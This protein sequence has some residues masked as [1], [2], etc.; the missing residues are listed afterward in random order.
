MSNIGKMRIKGKAKKGK[1]T[2]KA[3]IKHPQLSFQE[4]Q[5]AKKDATFITH[6]V[7][8]VNGE[9]VFE[10]SGSQFLS[11]NPYLKFSFNGGAKGDKIE[12]AV[13][14][15]VLAN[16]TALKDVASSG[17]KNKKTGKGKIK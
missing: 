17:K 8:T 1:T 16:N 2:V 5:R 7:G 6:V 13:E 11:K 9:T 12:L 4:A 3:M 14:E 10:M 15:V